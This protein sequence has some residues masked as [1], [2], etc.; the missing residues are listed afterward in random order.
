MKGPQEQKRINAIKTTKRWGLV[1]TLAAFFSLLI[2]AGHIW[3]QDAKGW[4][5]L[6]TGAGFSL[7]LSWL[8]ADGKDW[9]F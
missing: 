1:L 4:P 9:L 8:I 3:P 2:M 6:V 5:L 7:G